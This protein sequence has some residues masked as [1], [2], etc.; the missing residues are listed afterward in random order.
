M[1]VE[2]LVGN[3]CSM[4]QNLCNV[5][6]RVE[7]G[8]SRAIEGNCY[9]LLLSALGEDIASTGF[10]VQPRH[11]F[12]GFMPIFQFNR[13]HVSDGVS[14]IAF[15][16]LK[17]RL[18]NTVTPYCNNTSRI[19]S[20]WLTSLICLD[21]L[22]GN[23]RRPPII[24]ARVTIVSHRADAYL[25]FHPI[26]TWTFLLWFRTR[27]LPGRHPEYANFFTQQSK[28]QSSSCR[29]YAAHMHSAVLRSRGP[30]P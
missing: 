5:L 29:V 2:L 6:S 3:F 10:A 27:Y 13:R 21:S 20:F 18:S 24:C 28:A 11:R 25:L 30:S 26:G 7:L 12:V 23:Y 16:H 15:E 1:Q 19:A 14:E 22:C 9:S 17:V 8:S 4:H